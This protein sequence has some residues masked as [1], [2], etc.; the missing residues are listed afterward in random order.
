[1]LR[2]PPREPDP[3]L[4][5]RLTETP[6]PTSGPVLLRARGVETAEHRWWALTPHELTTAGMRAERDVRALLGPKS[7]AD[8]GAWRAELESARAAALLSLCARDVDEPRSPLFRNA[9]DVRARLTEVEIGAALARYAGFRRECGPLIAELRGEDLEAWIAALVEVA[10]LYPF[11]V[12][13]W[14][15]ADKPHSVPGVEVEHFCDGH[16]LCW[17]AARRVLYPEPEKK[18]A[19]RVTRQ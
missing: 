3:S 15:G 18:K 11:E 1:M 6:R 7:S 9:Q 2:R 10:Q 4:W 13:Q 12:L 16:F 8:S 19:A 17:V 14:G 5:S